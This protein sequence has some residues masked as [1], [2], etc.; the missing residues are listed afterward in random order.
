MTK[1]KT[2]CRLCLVRCGMVVEKDR[3]GKVKRIVGDR[4]HPLSKG[5][6]CVK[7]NASLDLTNSPKRIVHPMKRASA[8]TGDG[9]A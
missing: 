7:G 4:S 5:Y 2:T 1:I 8:A 3:A 9:S 6:L